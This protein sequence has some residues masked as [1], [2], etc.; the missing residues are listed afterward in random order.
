LDKAFSRR[1]DVDNLR[2]ELSRKE[3]IAKGP[4]LGV[5]WGCGK[6]VNLTARS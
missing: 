2:H 1:S 5:G 6:G 4:D 3:Q